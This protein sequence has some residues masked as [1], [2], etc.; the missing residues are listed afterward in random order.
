MCQCQNVCPG[1]WAWG[2]G[3][4]ITAEG[5]G[6]DQGAGW[7]RLRLKCPGNSQCALDWH[8]KA[9]LVW[10]TD[11]MVQGTGATFRAT[12]GQE[13]PEGGQEEEGAGTGPREA[14]VSPARDRS[15]WGRSG[16]QERQ[17]H[18]AK[19]GGRE[20]GVQGVLDGRPSEK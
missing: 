9:G 1:L 18:R 19:S 14:P 5:V 8:Q 16:G 7:E 15:L 12:P 17:G 3:R 11:V 13:G 4:G 10:R 6:K 20:L 2:T